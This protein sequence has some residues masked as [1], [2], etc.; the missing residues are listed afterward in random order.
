MASPS[1]LSAKAAHSADAN[2]AWRPLDPMGGM[3]GSRYGSRR[4]TPPIL[5]A[6][7]IAAPP[8]PPPPPAPA[9]PTP[10][11][12]DAAPP[13]PAPTADQEAKALER[14]RRAWPSISGKSV[15]VDV[16][17]PETVRGR[18]MLVLGW[19]SH[20]LR[21]APKPRMV[22]PR[23]DEE[24]PEIHREDIVVRCWEV[25]GAPFA[26]HRH[27]F[28]NSNAVQSKIS[29]LTAL[30]LVRPRTT[31]TLS[32]TTR[33]WWWWRKAVAVYGGSVSDPAASGL[34][35]REAPEVSSGAS[36]DAR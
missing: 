31:N 7:V 24:M 36:S 25:Y 13:A 33:G 21:D 5:P 1:P 3:M 16:L 20:N 27:D 29:D 12:A 19:M 15:K 11:S 22:T 4:P 10:A 9:A 26:M 18:V 14:A 34:F 32:V 28:P 8:P 17:N 35:E 23:G 6:P 30:G 2:T